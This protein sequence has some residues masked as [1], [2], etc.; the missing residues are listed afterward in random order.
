MSKKEATPIAQQKVDDDVQAFR[1]EF[2]L[3]VAGKDPAQIF[4][5]DQSGFNLELLSRRTLEVKGTKKVISTIRS[6]PSATHSYT[7]QFLISASGE[8]KAPLF[9]I[10]QEQGGRFGE[11]VQQ[12]MFRHQ[13][14][15]TVASTSGKINKDLMKEWFLDIYFDNVGVDS[16]LLLDSLTT[17]R[18]RA[19]IDRE[20]PPEKTY[21][22][23]TIPGGLTGYVQPL[24][25]YF[26]R[27]YKAIMRKFSDYANFYCEDTLKLHSRDVIFKLQTIIHKQFRSP[28]FT[29]FLKHSWVKAGLIDAP[30]H[31]NAVD[32]DVDHW[33]D[34]P[35]SFCFDPLEILLKP[36]LVCNVKPCFIRCAW[37]KEC[38]CFD[39]FFMSDEFH[40]CDNFVD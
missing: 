32:D 29:N 19:A 38:F 7:V 16:V 3:A 34:D 30:I 9:M 25:V 1:N 17:Y 5:T 4:N 40:Y 37:C 14:I 20:K 23:I 11:R 39:H 28:R 26:N 12:T 15:Y 10:M 24:D 2:K 33:F 18:D 35:N 36:C 13:E 22:V 8:L 27:P 21:T 31:D 6:K